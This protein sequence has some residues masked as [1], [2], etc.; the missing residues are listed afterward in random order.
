MYMLYFVSGL[1]LKM[2]RIVSCVPTTA[3]ICVLLEM[4]SFS[5]TSFKLLFYVLNSATSVQIL[6]EV[7]SLVI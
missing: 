7:S 3:A 1:R 5:V 4:P 6:T 2:L